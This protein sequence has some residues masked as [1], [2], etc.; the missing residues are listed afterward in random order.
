MTQEPKQTEVPEVEDALKQFRPVGPPAHL[1]A[2]ALGAEPQPQPVRRFAWRRMAF[3]AGALAAAAIVAMQFRTEP[4]RP[5]GRPRMLTGG[6]PASALTSG[7]RATFQAAWVKESRVDLGIPAEGASVLVVEFV[8]F[9][10]PQCEGIHRASREVLPGYVRTGRVKYV[11]AE[12]PADTSC[13]KRAALSAEHPG[14]CAAAAFVRVARNRGQAEA[15]EDWLF[16]N[17][18]RIAQAGPT[19]EAIVHIGASDVL[20]AVDFDGEY[21]KELSAMRAEIATE[22]PFIPASTPMIFVNGARLL[23]GVKPEYLDYAIQL[24]LRSGRGPNVRP[25][26][27]GSGEF[28]RVEGPRGRRGGYGGGRNGGYRPDAGVPFGRGGGR[29]G[30]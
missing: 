30:D 29:G 20:G 11:V 18:D 23:S 8:D 28:Q 15:M 3:I 24:E 6:S 10:C 7:E 4:G 26:D 19:A 9:L 22:R 27:N 21:R 2:R 14:A 1:R 16:A 12:W 25:Q 13:N 17:R 5:G